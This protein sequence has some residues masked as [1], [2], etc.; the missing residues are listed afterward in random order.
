MECPGHDGSPGTDERLHTPD[1]VPCVVVCRDTLSH[2]V[3]ESA[4]VVCLD[5]ATS[6][7]SLEACLLGE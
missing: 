4:P 3:Y 5:N 7:E 1:D 6:C 2:G